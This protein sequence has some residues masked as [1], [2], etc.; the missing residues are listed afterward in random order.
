MLPGMTIASGLI[1]VSPRSSCWSRSSTASRPKISSSRPVSWGSYFGEVIRRRF[2][3]EWE[4][5]PVSRRGCCRCSYLGGPRLHGFIP[6]MK[7]Y[8]RLTLGNGENLSAFY[9][10]VSGRLDD[11]IQ[12]ACEGV[13]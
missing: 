12:I 6:L 11:A 9:K 13:L 2:A 10:M 4:L 1:S 3:G 8:R 5:G 7:V